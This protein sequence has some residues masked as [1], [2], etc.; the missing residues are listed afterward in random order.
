MSARPS[1]IGSDGIPDLGQEIGGRHSR[2]VFKEAG[3]I[4]N[5]LE[6]ETPSYLGEGQLGVLYH[7]LRPLEAHS[8]DV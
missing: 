5:A 8:V 1:I 3:E 4:L 7:E 2:M 6:A